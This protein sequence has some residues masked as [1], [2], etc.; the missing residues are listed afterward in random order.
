[1]RQYQEKKI[2]SSDHIIIEDPLLL[3]SNLPYF[4]DC[5]EHLVQGMQR[6][7]IWR[8]LADNQEPSIVKHATRNS[9]VHELVPNMTSKETYFCQLLESQSILQE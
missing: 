1:M 2:K 9:I 7:T 8:M 4:P 5:Y 3:K 6:V